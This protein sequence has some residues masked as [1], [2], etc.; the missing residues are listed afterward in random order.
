MISNIPRKPRDQEDLVDYYSRRA[1]EYEQI[2]H[3]LDPYM[4]SE[5]ESISQLIMKIFRGHRILEVACGTGYW[6]QFAA[7]VA[8]SITATDGSLEML[9]IAKTKNLPAHKVRFV[10]ADAYRLE[11]I[12][13]EFDAGL[14]NFWFSHIPAVRVDEFLTGFHRRL[15]PDAVVF[16]ADNVYVPG[17][18]GELVT[19]SGCEDTFKMRKL[20]DG[21]R[22]IVLKNYY[23]ADKLQAIFMEI[24]HDLKVNVG[25]CFWWTSYKLP[26][27]KTFTGR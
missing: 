20:N 23:D 22:Y 26:S 27:R 6:T 2:Y 10:Q 21:S 11:S 13:G 3:R 24:G 25:H 7:R 14:A 5:L 8:D 1:S 9:K 4:Q 17:I 16:L 15:T 19:R 18:G 12:S